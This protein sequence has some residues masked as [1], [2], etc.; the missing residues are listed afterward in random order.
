MKLNRARQFVK[1]S[2]G[3]GKGLGRNGSGF[4]RGHI[5]STVLAAIVLSWLAFSW[6]VYVC[7]AGKPDA[8][9][10]TFGKALWWG[11]VTIL[12][13]G[14]GDF[15][16]VTVAGRVLAGFLMIAGVFGVA[17]IT[18]R[19]S[20]YFL[21]Q[22]LRKDKGIVNTDKLKDHFIV[23]GWKEDMH[24]LLTH[25]LDFN[26][27][28]TCQELVL[29]ANLTPAA[30]QALQE[31][32]R[33]K[34]L[35]IVIGHYFDALNLVKAAPER[36]RKVL[37]LADR[38][39]SATGA[40]PS[41]TEVDARTIMTAMTLSNIARGTLV[42]AEI[43]D[44][45]MDQ[46]LKLAQVSEIIYSRE[47][48][49]LLL[50]NASAGTGISNIIFDLLDPK[51]PTRINTQA[52][53]EASFN[54][55]Y[56]EFKASFEVRYPGSVVIGILE[57]TGNTHRI[58]EQALR[59]AQKTPDMSRLVTNLRSVKEMKCNHPV[60]NP[61]PD[62]MVPEG[63]MAIVVENHGNGHSDSKTFDST[64]NGNERAPKARP[65]AAA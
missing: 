47:Y 45:K 59:Q 52:I 65:S 13:V 1:A 63:S 39:P 64:E 17:I 3:L 25:I 9:I 8:N 2:T 34:E 21:E 54:H 61:R 29:I 26:P 15:Y 40:I 19:I 49:R 50:G 7:E 33:L 43:I 48:S 27:G 58:K 55:P 57:N 42:A 24:E 16:P 51:T 20:T 10:T 11:I 12:T 23:C 53:P 28:M 38:T 37:I 5:I 4:V 56:S 60:F 41:M 44:P 35:Q 32:P 18:S 36:A 62:F 31:H 22:V 14:Y 6:L 46:Y 30:A